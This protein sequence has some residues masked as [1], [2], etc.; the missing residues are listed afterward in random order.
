M[1]SNEFVTK[2]IINCSKL[3]KKGKL[4]H[5]YLGNINIYRDWGWAP[6]YVEAMYL[7]LRQKH[8]KDLVIG[9]G[10]RYSLRSFVYEVFRLLNIS[11]S[12]LKINIKKL[13]RK[14]DIITYK[15]DPKLAK[16]ILKWKAKTSFKKIIYKMVNEQL[17]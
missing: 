1:R 12:S 5:L 13:M 3:I 4:K 14:Q 6:E 10:K 9:S 17:Y 7:M 16:K 2:K 11:R 8:P 15:A